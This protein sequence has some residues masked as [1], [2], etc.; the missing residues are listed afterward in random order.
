MLVRTLLTVP[1]S[2]VPPP[3]DMLAPVVDMME[4]VV[5][6][7]K[8]FSVFANSKTTKSSA[9]L[10]LHFGILCAASWAKQALLNGST[11]GQMKI[12]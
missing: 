8:G 3:V 4:V 11:I 1:G 7:K 2:T 12:V 10:V 9:Q 6:Y 5:R